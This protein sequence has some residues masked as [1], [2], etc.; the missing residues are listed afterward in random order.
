MKRI[1][2]LILSVFTGGFALLAQPSL[3]KKCEV[4]YPEIL[5]SSVVLLERVALALEK[6]GDYGQKSTIRNANFWVV[7]S[8]RDANTTYTAPDGSTKYSSL[9]FNQQLRIAQIRN[10]Y[11]LVYT[12]PQEDIEYPLISQYAECKG[13]VSMK[14]LLLWHSCPADDVGIYKKALLCVNLE[15]DSGA[16]LGKIYFNPQMKDNF[17]R[18]KTDMKFYFV[19]K[20]EGDLALL[21]TTHTMDG[22]SDKVLSG[23]VASQSYVPWN[24]RSCL[25]PTWNH[26]DVEYFADE[27][28]KIRVC[29]GEDLER[30]IRPISFKRKESSGKYDRH[31]YRMNPD[32]LRF[33]ILDYKGSEHIYNC[34]S[35]GTPG[36]EA[37]SSASEEVE[38]PTPLGYS[39]QQL[40]EMLNINIGIVID[41][42]SSMEAFYP[43][44]QT[45]IKEGRKF[46]GAKYK[47]KVGVVIYR[48]YGDG[49]FVTESVPLTNPDNPRL[50]QFLENGGRYGIKSASSD[51][52][53]EEAM[54]QGVND[55]LDKLGFKPDQ[56]NLLLVVGDCGNDRADG[57]IS[58]NTIVDKLVE[59]NVNIMGF[60]VRN[61]VEDAFGLFNTQLQQM[62]K[63]SLE[64]KF[65]KLAKSHM[66]VS[67]QETRDGYRMV[68]DMKSNLYIGSHSFPLSGQ[69]MPIDKL[70]SLMQDAIMFC[71]ESVQYQIDVLVAWQNQ[72]FAPTPG[73]NGI[74]LDEQYLIEKLGKERYEQVKK[75]NSLI[76]F[77]GYALKSHKSG[78]S[79]FKPVVFLSSDELNAL[80]ERLAPVN[81]AAVAQTN[82]RDPYVRAMKA[83]IQS[84]VPD[85]TDERMN[86]MGYNE[87]MATAAGLNEAASALKGPSILEIANPQA[88]SHTEYASLVSDF[89]RKF[90]M[91]Q[92]LKTNPYKYIRIFNGIKYY[93]LPVEDLP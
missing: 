49:E 26:K 62:M 48:D 73:L 9:S 63:L 33:P 24:Q 61:G 81:N 64:K 34:S 80:I 2:L 20:R 74:D 5:Q 78:R 84:M 36:G 22:T 58:M 89:R 85:I 66:K 25:E 50:D 29:S 35:F 72:V 86:A 31:L 55:A 75:A 57:S 59:K 71:S 52:T 12:E 82:D 28:V 15:E 21:S 91:L 51:R 92:R 23:W 60:Q 7:Y 27:A 54:Y 40:N 46:F 69:Q 53:L 37:E 19:M 11:A 56:S 93:W 77:K 76:T 79:F 39:N 67:F 1:A 88:V 8:D 43:A 16:D 30:V 45:A 17:K 70:S 38:G 68:N 90:Q 32:E 3:P 87:V 44:V 18:L 13:W 42:T 4:F 14:K 6:S 10:G 83:L 41:G 47:V 65:S